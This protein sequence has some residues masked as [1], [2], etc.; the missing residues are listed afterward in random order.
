MLCY[1]LNLV[2]FSLFYITVLHGLISYIFPCSGLWDHVIAVDV[3]QDLS[4]I[5][6]HK[7]QGQLSSYSQIFICCQ[8][9]DFPIHTCESDNLITVQYLEIQNSII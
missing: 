9:V 7:V 5:H 3:I 4:H 8:K 6:I 1:T 2:S